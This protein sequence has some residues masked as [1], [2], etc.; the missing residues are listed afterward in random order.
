MERN[1]NS[2]LAHV[3][4]HM[5]IAY[6][7]LALFIAMCVGLELSDHWLYELYKPLIVT[8]AGAFFVATT[9]LAVHRC[10]CCGPR[11]IGQVCFYSVFLLIVTL[12][13]MYLVYFLTV[14]PLLTAGSDKTPYGLDKLLNVPPVVAA[15]WAAGVGWYI[16]F[17]ATAKGHRTNNA[18][19]LLMQTRTSKEFLQRT[20]TVQRIY[21]H[22]T[23]VP[24]SVASSTIA[25]LQSLQDQL[26]VATA[27]QKPG[28]EKQIRE[29]EAVVALRYM[30]NFYEFMAVGIEKNDLDDHLLYDTLGTHVPSI[31]RRAAEIVKAARGGKVP[32]VNSTDILAFTSLEPLVV[33][34]ERQ[35]MAETHALE[36]RAKA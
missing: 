10:A 19:S 7:G 9:A 27:A 8:M 36:A 20:E 3:S 17:Q 13:V 28:L 16:H 30:L 32:G 35:A 22:G 4:K 5:W 21:P 18:L 14:S 33:R 11:S 34:W 2:V 6:G 1:L 29:A 15:I 12:L 24:A 23:P 31:Y 25:T 26:L